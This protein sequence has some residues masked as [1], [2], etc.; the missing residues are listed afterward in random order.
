MKEYGKWTPHIVA[1]TALVVFIV[2]GLACAS[3]PKSPE[4]PKDYVPPLKHLGLSQAVM[5]INDPRIPPD[6]KMSPLVTYWLGSYAPELS[7]NQVSVFVLTGFFSNVRVDGN[8]LDTAGPA[9]MGFLYLAPGKHTITFSYVGKDYKSTDRQGVSRTIHAISYP[10]VQ[11]EAN[12]QPGK[13]YSITSEADKTVDAI[14]GYD[15]NI[16]ERTFR[17][18]TPD[19]KLVSEPTASYMK[20]TWPTRKYLEPYNTSLPVT[21]QALLETRN[22]VYIVNFDGESVRWGYGLDLNVTIGIPPG[23]HTLQLVRAGFDALYTTTINCVS[24]SRYVFSYIEAGG[25]GE[26][27]AKDVTRGSVIRVT[28]SNEIFDTTD[29]QPSIPPTFDGPKITI[30][31]RGKYYDDSTTFY[32]LFISPTKDSSWGPNLLNPGQVIKKGKLFTVQLPYPLSS[33][34]RY[35]IMGIVR[36]GSIFRIMDIEITGDSRINLYEHRSGNAEAW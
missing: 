22:N 30:D 28:K 20:S 25:I 21:S 6:H 14:L 12:M 5:N 17:I 19:W 13:F 8:L 34:N 36:G 3:S 4:A 10:N 35:D 33:V 31:H 16:D 2:L 15:N 32:Y 7:E 26:V 24:G 29:N 11:L 27:Q 18:A 1:V 9:N 23:R